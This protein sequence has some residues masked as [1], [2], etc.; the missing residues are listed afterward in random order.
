M[1]M[2]YKLIVTADIPHDVKVAFVNAFCLMEVCNGW[3]WIT[4]YG[5]TDDIKTACDLLN[6]E[7]YNSRKTW[8]KGG[9]I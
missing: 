7:G 9:K 8:Y 4:F 6:A 3:K 2:Y 1:K 5:V